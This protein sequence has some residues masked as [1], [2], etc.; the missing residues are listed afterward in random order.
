[1][2][3]TWCAMVK[4]K[5]KD[6][7]ESYASYTVRF[8]QNRVEVEIDGFEKLN[9]GKVERS[10]RFVL[11]EWARKQQAAVIAARSAER[12]AQMQMEENDV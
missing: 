2:L 12:G 1:M 4:K 8:F 3:C 7:D 6:E 5:V 10:L 11:D 9:P